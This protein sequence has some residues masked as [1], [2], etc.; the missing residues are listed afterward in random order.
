MPGS[1]NAG[2]MPFRVQGQRH[3]RPAKKQDQMRE[4]L[5]IFFDNN[6]LSVILGGWLWPASSGL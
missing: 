2:F 3:I 5:A 4:A 1:F 6:N